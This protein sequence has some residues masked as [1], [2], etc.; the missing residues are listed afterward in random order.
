MYCFGSRVFYGRYYY[1]AESN[2]TF[3]GYNAFAPLYVEPKLTKVAMLET[4]IED[5]ALEPSQGKSDSPKLMRISGMSSF[6]WTS[7]QYGALLTGYETCVVRVLSHPNSHWSCGNQT[8]PFLFFQVL[9]TASEPQNLDT[10]CAA[11]L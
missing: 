3:Y 11:E 2:E 4:V 9:N 5:A 8:H 7:Q 6:R 1:Y 10:G